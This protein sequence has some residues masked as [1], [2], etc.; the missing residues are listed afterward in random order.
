MK[1]RIIYI[2]LLTMSLLTVNALAQ[3]NIE[4]LRADFLTKYYKQLHSKNSINATSSL[5]IEVRNSIKNNETKELNQIPDSLKNNTANDLIIKNCLNS[6]K[7]KN[8]GVVESAILETI[9]SK[10]KFSVENILE[11][12]N[13]LEEISVE[14]ESD[15]ISYKAQLAKLYI[16]NLEWFENIDLV[17]NKDG[18]EIFAHIA[19]IVTSRMF[20]ADI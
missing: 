3:S 2:T 1:K 15:R 11:I 6:L 10:S 17:K 16:T 18:K 14:Y 8:G 19:K 4:K 20:V 9:I 5:N 7:S 12:V 13:V